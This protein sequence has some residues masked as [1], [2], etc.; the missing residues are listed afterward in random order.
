MQISMISLKH[1][2]K[3][4]TKNNREKKKKKE[5]ITEHKTMLKLTLSVPLSVQQGETSRTYKQEATLHFRD[6]SDDRRILPDKRKA[7]LHFQDTC[8]DRGTVLGRKKATP[9][10]EHLLQP[11]RPVYLLQVFGV[12]QPAKKSNLRPKSVTCGEH[13]SGIIQR[14]QPH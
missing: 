8:Y 5:K 13:P 10:S 4:K 14:I 2:L 7:T 12:L 6:T 1:C 3:N 9:F 11:C